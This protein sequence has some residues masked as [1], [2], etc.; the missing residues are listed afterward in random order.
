DDVEEAQE[1]PAGTRA[2]RACRCDM[3]NP[4]WR[5]DDRARLAHRPQLLRGDVRR[6]GKLS[7]ADAEIL[8]ASRTYDAA[9]RADRDRTPQWRADCCRTLAAQFGYA[10]RTLLGQFGKH[11]RSSLRGLLL[12]GHRLL[13]EARI[14]TF[15]AR[16]ARRTQTRA[17]ISAHD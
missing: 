3:R 13:L 1:H 7:G 2:R 14:E 17:R 9:P 16:R 12:P 8:R 10:V 4:A 5:R 6:K 15:R 11:R